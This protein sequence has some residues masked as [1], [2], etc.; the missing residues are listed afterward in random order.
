MCRDA[1]S[2][3]RIRAIDERL[4]RLRAERLRLAARA[5]HIERKRDTRRKIIVGAAVL[6]AVEHDG[7]PALRNTRE[8]LEWL[9]ARL[10]RPHDRALFDIRQAG[11][12]NE[13]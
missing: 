6:A 9:D 4:A 11:S 10:M 5:S 1:K 2:H 12:S 8:L 3:A 13:V 7:I